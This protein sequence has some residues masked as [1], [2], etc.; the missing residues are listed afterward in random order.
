MKT[1]LEMDRVSELCA[2]GPQFDFYRQIA[3]QYTAYVFAG[4]YEKIPDDQ[5]PA[6]QGCSLRA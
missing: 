4:Y 6:K 2:Q 3:L 1:R 5:K